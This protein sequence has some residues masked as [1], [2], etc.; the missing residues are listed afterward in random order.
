MTET[1][2]AAS[3]R[4]VAARAAALALV[5]ALAMLGNV[6]FLRSLGVEAWGGV[7]FLMVVGASSGRW[8]IRRTAAT[9]ARASSAAMLVAT[10]AIIG[11]LARGGTVLPLLVLGLLALAAA[12]PSGRRISIVACA[13]LLTLGG[14]AGF[15][16]A[17]WSAGSRIVDASA[18]FGIGAALSLVALREPH[19]RLPLLVGAVAA[20][21]LAAGALVR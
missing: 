8:A 13:L 4:T 12:E 6:P 5:V 11:A 18:G 20:A 19:T 21:A 1:S 15:L 2:H 10:G 14:A 7:L 16:G 3:V 17:P 9:S